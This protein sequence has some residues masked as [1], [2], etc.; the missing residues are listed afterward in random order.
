M[1]GFRIAAAALLGIAVALAAPGP[2]RADAVA[3]RMLG[4]YRAWTAKH[5]LKRSSVAII[6]DGHIVGSDKS[7][8][9]SPLKPEPVASVSKVITGIC[10]VKLVE[11]GRL[12]YDAPLGAVL[13]GYFAR[14]GRPADRRFSSITVAQLLT[15]TSGIGDANIDQHKLS[16]AEQ[17][18]DTI[19]LRLFQDPGGKHQYENK[20]FQVLGLIVEQVTG[21]PYEEACRRLVLEPA[22]AGAAHISLVQPFMSS[23]AGWIISARD[24]ALFMRHFEPRFGLLK[25]GPRDWPKVD[26]G[27]RWFY[28]VGTRLR[29]NEDDSYSAVHSGVWTWGSSTLNYQFMARFVYWGS[30]IGFAMNA[31]PS[32]D[33]LGEDLEHE[34]WKASLPVEAELP[35]PAPQAKLDYSTNRPGNDYRSFI[36]TREMKGDV[37]RKACEDEPQCKAYTLERPSLPQQPNSVCHLKNPAPALAVRDFCCASQV[38]R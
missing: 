24:M 13:A 5:K 30:G 34:M 18:R 9:T 6:R 27:D 26:L 17:M 3:E 16:L 32:I 8:A 2:A 33:G 22:G 12:Q 10:I 7:G 19:K 28:S 29:H 36:L 37:C 20:N 21:Q 4:A 23:W 38:L 15:Q 31:S 11:A 35:R 1:N 25:T 14:Y